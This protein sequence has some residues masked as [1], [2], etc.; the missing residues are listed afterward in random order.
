MVVAGSDR[1]DDWPR[2]APAGDNAPMPH[3]LRL[4]IAIVI[5]IGTLANEQARNYYFDRAFIGVSG[6][7]ESGCYDYSPE[8][9]E[10]K[11]AFIERARQVV[12]LCDSSKFDHRAMARI[13]E[14]GKCHVLVTDVTPPAH[15][16]QA[17]RAAGTRVLVAD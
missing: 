1:R 4:V 3:P 8:D 10:V 2:H 14:L 12:I 17:L 6:V 15:L 11:R 13:C 9:S 16:A 5:I 7:N